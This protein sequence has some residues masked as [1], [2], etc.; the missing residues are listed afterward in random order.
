MKPQAL[1][2]GITFD[3][4]LLVPQKT[5]VT[6]K[7][8]DTKTRLTKKISL[9]IPLVSAPMDTVTESKLAI[10]LALEGGLGFI[11]RNL[12]PEK[13]AEE[14]AKVKRFRNSFVENPLTLTPNH[15]IKDAVKIRQEKGYKNIP[16]VDAKGKLVGLITKFDYFWPEDQNLPIKKLMKGLKEIAIAQVGTSLAKA[17]KIIKNKKVAL[18]LI[19]DQGGYLKSIVT[20]SDLE[21]NLQYPKACKDTQDRLRVGGAVG[22]GQEALKR[23]MLMAEAGVDVLTIDTAHGYSQN[24]INILKAL[25]K[26]KALERV[27]IIAGNVATAQATKEFIALGADA[28]KVGV[29]PGSICTTRIVAGI[30]VP[31]FTAIKNAALGRGKSQ[32]PLIADGGIRYSGDIVKAL[33]AGADCVMIG[34]LFAATEESPGEMT[35]YNGRV[36]KVYRGMGSVEAMM[37][38]SRDRYGLRKDEDQSRL[39]PEGIVGQTLYKGK[40]SSHVH[41]LIG[42]LRAGM[43]YVGAKDINELHRK[44]V[45]LQISQNSLKESHPHDIT[46]TKEAPNYQRLW[47]EN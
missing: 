32:I 31:Q 22:V 9:S 35:Y 24:V 42:G 39:V 19:V 27:E 12:S 36:Y 15:L 10:A 30:G 26:E 47:P 17:Q 23:A 20:R 29:G 16:I 28:I 2:P 33:A 45:F 4:V 41:Q 14:V 18:L 40:L 11:H 6:P 34:K 7:E 1:E 44:A 37:H 38:G 3:D 5:K 46:I 43:G 8:V 13:Q 25:K 21:K